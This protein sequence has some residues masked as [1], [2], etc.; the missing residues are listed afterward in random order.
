MTYIKLF[1][2]SML[3][4][5]LLDMTWIGYIAKGLYFKSYGNWLRLENGRLLPVWWATIIIYA[6]F[7]VSL[8]SIGL[9]ALFNI[10]K[11]TFIFYS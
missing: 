2:I 1:I 9:F 4:F 6:L 10:A 11:P 5:F 8:I 7:A 3:V